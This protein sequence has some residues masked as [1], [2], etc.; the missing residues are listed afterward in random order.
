M[1]NLFHL[2]KK[3]KCCLDGLMFFAV[4][5]STLPAKAASVSFVLDQSNKLPDSE[6]ALMEQ[7]WRVA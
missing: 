4:M 2:R 1:N 5:S 3:S 7:E 6:K